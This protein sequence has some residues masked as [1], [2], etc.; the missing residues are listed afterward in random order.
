MRTRH[1]VDGVDLHAAER[2]DDAEQML[3]RDLLRPRL[4]EAL[5]GQRDPPRVGAG[6]L[7]HYAGSSRYTPPWIDSTHSSPA[8]SSP[9]LT[10][11]SIVGPSGAAVVPDNARIVPLQ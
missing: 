2:V 3:R 6:D 9:K 7:E 4:G 10:G 5:R 8:A 11:L 1:H